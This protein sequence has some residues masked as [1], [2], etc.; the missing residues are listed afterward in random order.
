M[1]TIP[2]I[3]EAELTVT[4]NK[5]YQGDWEVTFY[6][7]GMPVRRYTLATIISMFLKR[8]WLITIRYGVRKSI[9]RFIKDVKV[10]IAESI[11]NGAN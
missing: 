7:A 10:D 8:V 1:E 6:Y 4:I 3:S 5:R 9:D 11:F 2:T